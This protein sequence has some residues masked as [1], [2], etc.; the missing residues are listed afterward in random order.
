MYIHWRNKPW[1][2]P[3]HYCSNNPT[4][5]IDPDGLTDFEINANDMTIKSTKNESADRVFSID[6]DGKK[7]LV[8]TFDARTLSPSSA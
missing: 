7:S 8:S 4:N 5:R 3:Y 2:T 6:A 1:L